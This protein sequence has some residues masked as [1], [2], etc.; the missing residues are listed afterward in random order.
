MNG[1]LYRFA[2]GVKNTG[3]RL[4]LHGLISLGFYLREKA[5]HG[6]IKK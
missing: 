3:V 1:F 5:F 4:R 6:K 2:L